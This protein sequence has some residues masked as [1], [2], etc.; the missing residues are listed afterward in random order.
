MLPVS[1]KTCS[2]SWAGCQA[3][4]VIATLRR[5]W[6]WGVGR[7]LWLAFLL[8]WADP[9]KHSSVF[10]QDKSGFDFLFHL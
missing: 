5:M 3:V 6:Q 4:R 9:D 1:L 10:E 8:K 2:R 7:Q